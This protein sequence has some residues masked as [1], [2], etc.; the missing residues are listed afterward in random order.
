MLASMSF[1]AGG[2]WFAAT[3]TTAIGLAIVTQLG[4]LALAGLA[5]FISWRTRKAVNSHLDEFKTML[6][7]AKINEGVLKEKAEEAKRKGDVAEGL[8]SVSLKH[9]GEVITPEVV[10]APA[11]AAAAGLA[12]AIKAVPEKTAV[13][14]VEKLEE[15]SA[16]EKSPTP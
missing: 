11:K 12:A 5:A 14:V 6:A 3:D 4:A 7:Q 9:G 8:L 15:K 10:I 1:S 13:K 2:V 16:D